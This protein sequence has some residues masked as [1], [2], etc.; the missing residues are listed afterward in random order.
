MTDSTIKQVLLYFSFQYKFIKNRED[1]V[2]DGSA[3]KSTECF[4]RRL[5]FHSQHP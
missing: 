2:R 5:R 1:G 4:S 3:I